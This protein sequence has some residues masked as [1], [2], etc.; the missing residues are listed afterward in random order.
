V[1]QP[2][3]RKQPGPRTKPATPGSVSASA[4][5]AREAP[6]LDPS[7]VRRAYRLERAKRRARAERDRARRRAGLRFVGVLLVLL[8]VAV[9]LGLTAWQTVE[10]VFGL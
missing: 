10:R 2:A 1:A 3:R 9:G 5:A 4:A 8:A 7:A 6:P